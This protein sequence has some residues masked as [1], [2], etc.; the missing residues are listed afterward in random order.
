MR[1]FVVVPHA[2]QLELS[3]LLEKPFMHAPNDIQPRKH[4]A[5]TGDVLDL[6]QPGLITDQLR[7]DAF[8]PLE[9]LPGK[10]GRRRLAEHTGN[11]RSQTN[12]SFA[13][14]WQ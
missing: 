9:A 3:G 14:T 12:A 6:T 11:G 7:D 5:T 1:S 13:N 2:H 10:P 8:E 4:A